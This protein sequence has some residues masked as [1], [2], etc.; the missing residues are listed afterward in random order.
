MDLPTT[1][2]CSWDCEGCII[3]EPPIPTTYN[4]EEESWE[5][6]EF[7]E[8][9]DKLAIEMK[10]KEEAKLYLE[11]QENKKESLEFHKD[12]RGILNYIRTSFYK[13]YF[14]FENCSKTYDLWTDPRFINFIYKDCWKYY[15]K[16]VFYE[17]N[18]YKEYLFCNK[19]DCCCKKILEIVKTNLI[20][21]NEKIDII[22]LRENILS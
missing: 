5:N 14:M 22:K 19:E 9:I 3:C 13:T 21:R 4:N 8:T 1:P 11:I 2:E 10:T 16:R 7:I 15:V 12:I 6:D 17:N 18:N 20:E